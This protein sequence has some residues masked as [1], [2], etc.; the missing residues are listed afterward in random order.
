MSKNISSFNI[1][2]VTREPFRIGAKQDVMSGID[3]PL[4]TV[5]GKSRNSGIKPKGCIKVKH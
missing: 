1:K 5:G 4:T 2:L 3:N